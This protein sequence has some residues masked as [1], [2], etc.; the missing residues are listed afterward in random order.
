MSNHY[1]KW[2]VLALLWMVACLNTWTGWRFCHLPH[3]S[4]RDAPV[5]CLAGDAR[6]SL[7]LGIWTL[8]TA[9]WIFR[10]PFPA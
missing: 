8:L 9:E 7:P 10:R 4:A 2:L 5:K 3:T 1:S 6:V